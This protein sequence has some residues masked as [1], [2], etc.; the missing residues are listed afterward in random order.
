MPDS[1]N[2][3]AGWSTGDKFNAVL[4]SAV[5]SEAEVAEYCRTKAIHTSQLRAWKEACVQANDWDQISSAQLKTATK[6]AEKRAKKLEQE[7]LRKNSALAE[8]AALLI[9]RGKLN[10]AFGE[11]EDG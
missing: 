2:T 5:M 11:G 4:E 10:A 3:P 8:A 7:I 6:T 1:N 9:L